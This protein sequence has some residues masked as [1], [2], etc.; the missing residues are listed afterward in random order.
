MLNWFSVSF[1]LLKNDVQW[2]FFRAFVLQPLF[3]HHLLGILTPG[4]TGS[5][6]VVS[7]ELCPACSAHFYP[8]HCG[9]GRR[10]AVYTLHVILGLMA[11]GGQS[12]DTRTAASDRWLPETVI[13]LG[14]V[15]F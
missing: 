2:D 4:G 8:G 10:S 14:E 11:A 7:C 15:T 6:G 13:I 5:S 12:P 1:F 3:K 9:C